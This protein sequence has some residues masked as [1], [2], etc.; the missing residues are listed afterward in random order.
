MGMFIETL[1]YLGVKFLKVVDPFADI[2]KH[3][4][5]MQG[6]IMTNIPLWIY[7]DVYEIL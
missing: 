1:G 4:G 2:L 5:I 6:W 3:H 7:E